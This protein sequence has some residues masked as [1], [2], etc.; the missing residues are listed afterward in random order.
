MPIRSVRRQTMRRPRRS[1]SS[2]RNNDRWGRRPISNSSSR[3]N[4][5]AGPPRSARG[6]PCGGPRLAGAHRDRPGHDARRHLPDDRSRRARRRSGRDLGVR[7][8]G[9]GERLR[10]AVLR[11]VRS[12]V[13]V[14]GSAYSYATPR[15]ANWSPGSSGGISSS[16]TACRSRRRRRRSPITSSTCWPTSGSSSGLGADGH[17]ARRAS[18]DRSSSQ[19]W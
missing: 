8:V 19:G 10:R 7:S 3:D 18:A 16:N 9:I 13:P 6:R 14:A 2:A 11:G 5:S 1:A 15:S 4:R 12:M 17:V